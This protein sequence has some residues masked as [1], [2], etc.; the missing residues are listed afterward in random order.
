MPFKEEEKFYG[1]LALPDYV[2]VSPE[3]GQAP[4]LDQVLGA[5]F[6]QE[7]PIVSALNATTYDPLKPFDP[8]F[9]PWEEIQGTEY[10]AYSERFS[11]ARDKEDLAAMKE[12][13]D[14]ELA[15]RSVLDSSGAVGFA[16]QMGAALLSPTS[17]IP[18]GAIVKGGKGVSIARTTLTVGGSAA[19]AA[20]I[21]EMALQASQQT[22]TAEESAFA[23]GGS[24]IL[25][26]V[27]GAAAG[28]LS[29]AQFKA[30]AVRTEQALQLT[31]DYD[32]ALRSIGA[33]ENR[34]DLT[35]RR[36]QIFQAVNKIPALRA[37]VRSD[38]V[39]RAQL[40]PLQEVRGALVD[41]VE[42]PL[43]YSVNDAGQSVRRGGTSVEGRILARERN[44]LAKSISFLSRS[45]AEYAKDGPVG[46]VGT[47]T[48]PVTTR[49]N[50]L[51]GKDRKLS[52][53]EFM[54]EVGKAMRRGDKHPIPQ[55]QSAADALR[56]E[57]FDKIKDEAIEVGIFDADLGVKNA[58]SYFSRV[59]N[60]ERI[61]QHFGDGSENDIA[62]VLREEFRKRRASAQES[63][64]FDR[65]V[66]LLEADRF[67]ARE[68][69]RTA[70]RALDKA[71]KKAKDKRSRAEAAAKR[72]QAVGRVSRKLR[73]QFEQR[74]TRLREG[75]LEGGDLE[76]F[77]ETL[78]EARGRAGLEPPDIL[79]TVRD[80]GGIRDDGSGE[81]AAALDTK[82]LSIS[83]RD[84]M[85]A[86]YMREA[87]EEM[88]YLPEGST[89]NDLYDA[90][91]SAAGG[92]K[93]Y[94]SRENPFELS[95]FQAANEFA[96]A[97]EEMGIDITEPIDRIIAQLP[98]KARNQ[99]TQR[100]K[101]KE[102]ERSGKK[103][104][105]EDA[106]ADV[107][108]LRALDRLD[109]ANA[110]LAELKNDIGPK[111]Q[112]EI[113][114]AQ[115]DLRTILP[116]LRKAKKAQSAE[117]F[118]ANADDLQIEEA[119]TDTVRS[120]L[121]LKPG[122][123][124]Y[125]AT[126]SSP[127]R[128]RV[129]DV[130][131]LVL[132]PWL[133]S[134]AEAIMSQYFRQMVPD[135]ELTRQ[136]GDAEMTVARQRITEEIARNMQNAKSAKDRVRIQEEGQ[137]RLKDLEGMRDRLRNRYGVPENPRNGWVQGGRALRTVSY[138]GYLGG[139][140]LSA[141]P[142]IAGI[143]GR[144]GIEGAFGAG[145][146]ALTNPKRMALASRDM[147]EIGAAAEWWLNSRALSLAEMFD[148]YGGGT[149]ME[150]VLGQGARQFSIATGMIPWNIGWKSVGGA[151]VASKMSKAADAVRA[152]KATKKQLRT[153]AENGIE[154]WMAERI[155][156]QLDEFADKGGTLWL[157]RGQ[158]WTDPEAFKA[159]ENAM[160]R[161]FDLM[162][163]T[164][165]QDKPLSFS[166]EMGKFF[167]QFKSFGI[168]AHHRILLSG[169]QRADADVLAQ[170]TTAI[171]LGALTANV[172]ASLGGYEPKEGA[173]MWED[174][175]DRSGLAGWLMEPY[176]LAAALSGGKTSITGEP[177]SRYQARSAL[178][179]ALGPSVDM[180]KGGVEAI[181]A[182]S[183]G[184]ANYRDVR[185]L[186]RPIP[187]NNLW[188][189]LPLFQKVEDAVVNAT[190]AKP[191]G[192]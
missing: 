92:E 31:A 91:R 78:R 34:A 8:D 74:A 4:A 40:S 9:R 42:T 39:L 3:P 161:E 186:M 54:E 115:A 144:G 173:A 75:L 110:R 112:E 146:T 141:I 134:N 80:L 64:A 49:F 181:N 87:L 85:E 191:R 63:L 81:L 139:M 116:E 179:G 2:D 192:G 23:I 5:A 150:R 67:K 68:R 94:S 165:G 190:G 101:A 114:A 152:G 124:S 140:M 47:L 16:S 108:A 127:T 30:A 187:G 176:N 148:P 109:E 96:K 132:E 82:K 37:I 38:P 28:K 188:Y 184:K 99:K 35:L 15:D 62:E 95:R 48:A 36:E 41:L 126:L 167:G 103:A 98:D 24:F 79:K 121:N 183:N 171:V 43:Q 107:R 123:H 45:F 111:V 50:N 66:E 51:M 11:G 185:K 120:L 180:M 170:V 149:K 21:D 90:L 26:G 118:Y 136:F 83:R 122:Q 17:L 20:G 106:G 60:T 104:G 70:Q 25:G 7:N 147:A 18:G 12:A 128:A 93:I 52:A 182:F 154:P 174:A 163:I 89:V 1:P 27:L 76:V 130:D 145:V 160:N 169:I 33:A 57:I 164:P 100:A 175:L 153:L 162:V 65:T 102:A 113:K 129:L 58:D 143:I 155:A 177:V 178:E 135:L 137:E 157:P 69:A 86:D 77:K 61:R 32:E 13:I 55:V 59:Y 166:T 72:E 142:D 168:S 159:F 71:V 53:P 46:T 117:E 189:L 44:E 56:R 14:Q 6:R 19:F 158:E 97:M 125:E 10:E 156:A 119:V 172:K 105:K 151:A 131:D 22:R 133:E 73:D 84:G 29:A 138:M 88:G